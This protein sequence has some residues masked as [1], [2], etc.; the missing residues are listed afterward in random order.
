MK[1]N[2]LWIWLGALS[3]W[4]ASIGQFATDYWFCKHYPDYDWVTQSLSYQGRAGGPVVHE[5]AVWGV[6]FSVL[7]VPFSIGFYRA[8]GKRG[9]WVKL[10]AS[11]ILLYGL[12]EGAGSGLIPVENSSTGMA[13]ATLLHDIFSIIGDAGL[14]LLPLVMVK[15]FLKLEYPRFYTYAWLTFILGLSFAMMFTLTKFFQTD[16]GLFHY[17]GIW[18]RLYIL[19]FHLFLMTVSL[20]MLN[21]GKQK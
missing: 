12:G 20:K 4:A 1:N 3:C 10:A 6:L 14:F 13:P 7:F 21:P 18:Q 2:T 19:I 11:M 15:I 16:S 8:F 9:K 17:R 5:V